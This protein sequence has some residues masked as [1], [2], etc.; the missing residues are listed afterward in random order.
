M[1]KLA[2]ILLIGTLVQR[3]PIFSFLKS[4]SV[5]VISVLD[6]VQ[7]VYIIYQVMVKHDYL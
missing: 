4:I 1:V 5:P 3:N 2:C 6:N 7:G